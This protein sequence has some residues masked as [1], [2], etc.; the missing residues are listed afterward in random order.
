MRTLGTLTSKQKAI[1][2]LYTTTVIFASLGPSGARASPYGVVAA[3]Y[4]RAT[5]CDPPFCH[6][7]ATESVIAYSNHTIKRL[8]AIHNERYWSQHCTSGCAQKRIM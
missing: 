1:K 6:G 3:S 2:V 4:V 8:G 7:G 5:P